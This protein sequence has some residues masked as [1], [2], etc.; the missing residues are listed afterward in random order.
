MLLELSIER[1]A[2]IIEK[3]LFNKRDFRKEA[4]EKG[5]KD[6]EETYQQAISEFKTFID[7]SLQADTS[8]D[9]AALLDLNI[10]IELLFDKQFQTDDEKLN[11]LIK[12]AKDRFFN[13]KDKQIALEKL[14]DAFERIKTYFSNNKRQSSNKLVDLISN[15][16][17]EPTLSNEFNTLTK[18]GND[19]R[20]RHHETDKREISFDKHLNYLFFRM[21]ALIDLCLVCIK[22]NTK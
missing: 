9:L 19:F 21:L 11:N 17:D 8:I 14:W 18:I 1:I 12:E 7:Q 3:G 13:P 15:G 5:Q 22:E 4:K 16:F 20:I 10:N 2:Y 6:F